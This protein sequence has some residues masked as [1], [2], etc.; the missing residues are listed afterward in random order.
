V[1]DEP[2][3]LVSHAQKV[4]RPGFT[5]LRII[6]DCFFATGYRIAERGRLGNVSAAVL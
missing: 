3:R 4:E 6:E 1:S 2:E 5:E